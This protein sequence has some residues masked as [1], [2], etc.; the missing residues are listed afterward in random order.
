MTA[1]RRARASGLAERARTV[2]LE[3]TEL[4]PKSFIAFN[5]L[6]H[7][8]KHDLVGRIMKHGMD[9]KGAIAAYRKAIALDPKDKDTR[10]DLALLLEYDAEGVRYN[11]SVSLKQSVEVLRDLKKLDEEYERSYEDNILFDL[12]YVGDYDGMLVYAATLP[13]TE[14]RKGLIV[15]ATTLRESTEVALKKSLEMTPNDQSRSKILDNAAAVLIRARKYPE[16][17]A[18][19]SAAASEQGDEQRT[20]RVALIS[21]TRPYAEVSVAP[22]KPTSVVFRLFGQLLSG[23][24]KLPEYKSMLYGGLQANGEL[25]DEKQFQTLMSKLKI[26]LSATGSPPVNIA[27]T[28]VSNMRCTVDGDDEHAHRRDAERDAMIIAGGRGRGNEGGW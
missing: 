2:A 24:L 1:S 11:D 20:R 15:A 18:I 21:K 19:L 25:P 17:A 4:E 13:A 27:D 22:S 3:G 14:V 16:A 23:N 28:V 9:Y 8:L 10:V 6:G 12:W 5:T 26:Q 7:V